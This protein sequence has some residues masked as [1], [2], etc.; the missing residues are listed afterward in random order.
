M[1]SLVVELWVID[2]LSVVALASA[3]AAHVQATLRELCVPSH[4]RPGNDSLACE[5]LW[6][7]QQDSNLQPRDYESPALTVAP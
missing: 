5:F 3:H 1:F 4:K 7:A 2:F 6:W